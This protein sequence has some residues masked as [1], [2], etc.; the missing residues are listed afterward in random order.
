MHAT[1][2]VKKHPKTVLRAASLQNYRNFERALLSFDAHLNLILGNN[3]QGKTNLLEAIHVL[4]TSRPFAHVPN[5]ELVR[6]GQETAKLK[7]EFATPAGINEVHVTL[8]ADAKSLRLNGKVV[9]NALALKGR[10]PVV[11]FLPDDV[12]VV[13]GPPHLRRRLLDE[14]LFALDPK[15]AEDAREYAKALAQRNAV[16]QREP[17]TA[18]MVAPW[19]ELLARH[20]GRMV[21]RRLELAERL[22]PMVEKIYRAVSRDPR[23]VALVYETS[24]PVA[25]GM[26]QSIRQGL[27]RYAERDR[28]MG[29]TTVGPHRDKV[30]ITLDGR[31]AATFASQGEAKTLALA[32]RCAEIS[33][34]RGAKGVSPLVLLD[35]I[36]S[37]LDE[38]RNAYLFR[39][40]SEYDGQL[41]V[42]STSRRDA[43]LEAVGRVFRISKGKVS[44]EERP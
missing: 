11:V 9:P 40:L 39:L 15:H 3:G 18:D 13:K 7:G 32:L 42:T 5:R 44:I 35:D 28:R 36:S 33:L 24:F 31:S 2:V 29:H 12:A 43:P 23:R 30:E 34:Y 26:E 27:E 21:T 22:S 17:Q 1:G 19:N 41:F 38:S 10:F 14:M 6:F 37:E 4:C 20:G 25:D 16:L 8:T